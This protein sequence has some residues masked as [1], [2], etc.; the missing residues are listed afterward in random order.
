VVERK[1][2]PSKREFDLGLAQA[3]KQFSPDLV[4]LAGFM[5]LLGKAF[6]DEFPDKSLIFTL[7]SSL[8]FE[9]WTPRSRLWS[10]E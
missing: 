8:L 4:I 6:L 3:A 10:T 7:H 5:R 9:V 2:Y 1:S